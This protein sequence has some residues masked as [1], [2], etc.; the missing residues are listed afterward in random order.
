MAL[1]H[2]SAEG[3]CPVKAVCSGLFDAN[4]TAGQPAKGSAGGFKVWPALLIHQLELWAVSM[5]GIRIMTSAPSLCWKV[6]LLP[7]MKTP[8]IMLAGFGAGIRG[9]VLLLQ[10]VPCTILSAFATPSILLLLFK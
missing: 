9:I 5:L 7:M 2:A 3:T 10:R 4:S 1:P 6:G 8:L